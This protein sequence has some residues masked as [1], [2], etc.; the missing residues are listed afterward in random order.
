MMPLIGHCDFLNYCASGGIQTLNPRIMRPV[1]CHCA[2]G[3]L[4]VMKMRRFFIIQ[5]IFLSAELYFQ[6]F[7]MKIWAS[8]LRNK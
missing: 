6:V 4:H 5:N 7:L 8:I 2:S 1:L 3:A